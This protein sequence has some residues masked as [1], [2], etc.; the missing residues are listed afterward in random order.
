MNDRLLDPA[1][2]AAVGRLELVARTVVEGF[3]LGL[4]KSPYHGLSQEFAVHRPYIPGD[5]VRHVDWR[6]FA[7][8]DRLYVKK[9]EEET[10]APVRLLLDSSASL[11]FAPRKLSKFD[12]A[13]L[14]V[15]SLAYIAI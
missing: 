2:I 9:F 1:V 7:R 5:E 15:A 4:H 13:R 11:S 8:S 10:N 6:L 14:L 12:Y 3:L